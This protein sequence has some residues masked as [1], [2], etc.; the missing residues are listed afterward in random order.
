MDDTISFVIATDLKTGTIF[1]KDGQPWKVEKY[2]H[3]KSARSGVTVKIRARN[4]VTGETRDLSYS[5]EEKVD[6]AFVERKSTQFL[7]QNDSYVFMDPETYDQFEIPSEVLGES[8]K[9]LKEGGMVQV[10]YY[11]SKPVSVELPNNLTY[12]V[13]Y[14]EPGYKGNTVS[15]VYKDAKVEGGF[16]VKVPSFIEIGDKIKVDTR[17]GEYLSKA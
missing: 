5:G 6:D 12:E 7:Y 4:L 15:N 3:V 13:I 10:L 2:S 9:F 8:A 11:N 1:E 14:T 16:V 17:T